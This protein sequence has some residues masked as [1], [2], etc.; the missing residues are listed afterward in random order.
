[1]DL[2]NDERNFEKRWLLTLV[3]KLSKLLKNMF[4]QP[5]MSNK[6]GGISNFLLCRF[7]CFTDC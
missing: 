6:S 3:K 5:V 7:K 4:L 1:M 2:L